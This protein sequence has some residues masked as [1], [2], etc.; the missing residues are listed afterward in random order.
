[1]VGGMVQQ[2]DQN[3]PRLRDAESAEVLGRLDD[4]LQGRVVQRLLQD[5]DHLFLAGRRLG[6]CLL[7]ESA[8]RGGP[9]GRTALAELL[10]RLSHDGSAEVQRMAVLALGRVPG[11]DTFERLRY[12]VQQGRATA[13]HTDRT[14]PI[15]R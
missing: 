3:G 12:L 4:D 2:T 10:M 14:I 8:D 7:G 9:G 5:R 1:M 15:P 11:E 13:R 6:T